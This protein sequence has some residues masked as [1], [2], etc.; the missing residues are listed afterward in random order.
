MGCNTSSVGIQKKISDNVLIPLSTTDS[1]GI[2]ESVTIQKHT[3]QFYESEAESSS[4][5]D[6]STTQ[7]TLSPSF[8]IN[9]AQTNILVM[10][11]K[12]EEKT[13]HGFVTMDFW[14]AVFSLSDQ[15]EIILDH[16]PQSE[17]LDIMETLT[18]HFKDHHTVKILCYMCAEILE[19]GSN[20]KYPGIS[21][22]HIHF[23]S[24]LLSVLVNCSDNNVELCSIISK[25]TNFL[26][27][28]TKK[29]Q[30][31][32]TPHFDVIDTKSEGG[33]HILESLITVLH[34]ITMFEDNVPKVRDVNCIEAMK[35]YLESKDN[36]IRLL[37]LATL[38]DLVNESESEMIKTMV[39]S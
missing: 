17:K 4:A 22:Q 15:L 5:D 16:E 27:T 36:T 13:K 7:Q 38:A 33:S 9:L 35:P 37:C 34:N 2:K 23:V 25:Q 14:K 12:Y 19:P 18:Q 28:A 1:S 30:Q 21:T 6:A 24:S 39:M 32:K 26:N 10:E 8:L 20:S 29:L 31:W 11:E 3:E